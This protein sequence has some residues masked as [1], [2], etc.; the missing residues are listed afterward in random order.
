MK[1]L[2]HTA[3]IAVTI[4]IIWFINAITGATYEA[5]RY[6]LSIGLGCRV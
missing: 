1:A 6:S 2:C 5:G 3:S 4:A